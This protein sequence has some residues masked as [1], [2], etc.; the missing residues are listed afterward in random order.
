MP[1]DDTTHGGLSP[2]V[3]ITNQ[4]TISAGFSTSQS[5]GDI[6]LVRAG[7][8]SWSKVQWVGIE[9]TEG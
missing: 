6:F 5:D 7:A 3:S 9:I 8:G 1:R 2:P 4:E